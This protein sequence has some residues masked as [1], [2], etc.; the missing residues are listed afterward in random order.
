MDRSTVEI[1]TRNSALAG[2]SSATGRVGGVRVGSV[3]VIAAVMILGLPAPTFA[4][5]AGSA[6]LN[7]GTGNDAPEV[8]GSGGMINVGEPDP[9]T[10][11]S[12]S[13]T[14][15][16]QAT[17]SDVA[18][19]GGTSRVGGS[20]PAPT[21]GKPAWVWW[22]AG[23]FV[24]MLGA[25]GFRLWRSMPGEEAAEPEDPVDAPGSETPRSGADPTG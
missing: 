6:G 17:E 19:A 13:A 18:P 21:P 7:L 12:W 10:L 9:S 11:P 20:D 23:A 3:A 15:D 22:V 8:I 4:A 1:S 14:T 16:A 25:G 2:N 5:A 24:L